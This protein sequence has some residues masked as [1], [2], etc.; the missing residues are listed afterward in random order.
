[1]VSPNIQ[2]ANEGILLITIQDSLTKNLITWGTRPYTVR[3]L[4]LSI[5]ILRMKQIC[6]V[7]GFL[8]K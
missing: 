1:M 3:T 7:I 5:A 6:C 8:V 2:T 4:K